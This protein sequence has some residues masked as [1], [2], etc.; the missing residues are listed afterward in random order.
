MSRLKI[1]G[2]FADWDSANAKKESDFYSE[3]KNRRGVS[4]EIL[5]VEEEKGLKYS[6]KY[7][8]RNVPAILF[9]KNGQLL[10]VERGNDAYLKIKDYINNTQ[11]EY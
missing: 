2:L 8:I 7:G 10:G 4:Y 5:N 6:I 1:I 9:M 11:H 3:V